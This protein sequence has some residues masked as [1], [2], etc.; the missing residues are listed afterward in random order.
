[1]DK[2][3]VRF[4][5]I[6]LISSAVVTA[7][8]YSSVT[9]A[10]SIE[11]LYDSLNRLIEVRYP[12]KVI[13]YTYDDAGNR[14]GMTVEVL[15]VAPSITSLSPRGAVA[16]ANPFSL[17]IY[18]NEFTNDSYVQWNG[19]DRP[20]TFV[21][22]NELIINVPT[23]DISTIGTAAIVVIKPFP[24]LTVS[25]AHTFSIVQ[26]AAF[27]GQ[28]ASGGTGLANVTLNLT[29]AETESVTSDS[30]GN[31]NFA[32]LNNG[33]YTITPVRTNYSFNPASLNLNYSGVSQSNLNFAATLVSYSITGRVAASGGTGVSGVTI[34]LSGSETR[35][36][37]TDSN[38]DYSIAAT[39]EGDYTITPSRSNYTFAPT[40][41]SFTNLSANQSANFTGS[42]ITTHSTR[43]DFDGDSKADISIFRPSVGEWWYLKSS[44]GGN[45]A[46]QFGA[47][48]DKMVPADFT[49]DGRT[50]L[51]FFRPSTAEWFVLRSEDDSFYSFPFGAAGD[52]P[53]PGDYDGDGIA[54]PAVFRPTTANWFII[55]S[56]DGQ[57]QIS[58][59]GANGDLP[60]V[61][62]Y[63]N[64]GKDDLAIYR[65]SVAEYWIL[66]S[67]AGIV[68]YQFGQTGDR[69]LVADF[70]GDGTDDAGFW[71][72][73]TGEWF[74][75]RSEDGSFF[76]FPFGATGD[77][78][79][80]ADYD[81]DGKADPTVF[82]PNVA[83]WF[84][85]QSTNGT[86]ITGFGATNDRPVPGAYVVP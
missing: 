50:D 46:V 57:V 10:G 19:E 38:G 77:I 48:T 26:Q 27:A 73:A 7:V 9:K 85:A 66:R 55:R 28:V 65:P 76:S 23:A 24:A 84:S 18:G 61:G 79:A 30:N 42:P 59:F 53:A 33:A 68:A 25:N 62:D 40:S 75:L 41:L 4:M 67:T 39:A 47:G 78:P 37:T 15:V 22:S 82:R 13:H 43:F 71:R 3:L 54:D 80:P 81:G 17:K 20:T 32:V 45:Y 21:S 52:I 5:K 16:G 6:L 44:N 14:T 36:T 11:Y 83:T 8:F 1:M 2:T 86:V 34:S 35:Q 12:D 72:P 51:A 31:F 69:A 60:L 63:D 64:D 58:S 49:G 56:S 29:G 70:T 74:I